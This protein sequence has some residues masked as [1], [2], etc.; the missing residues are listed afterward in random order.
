M[1]MF[2]IRCRWNRF[3]SHSL[4]SPIVLRHGVFNRLIPDAALLASVDPVGEVAPKI[5]NLRVFGKESGSAKF[6]PIMQVCLSMC[7]LNVRH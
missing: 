5:N 7:D 2:Y 1:L 4:L 3:R 6:N